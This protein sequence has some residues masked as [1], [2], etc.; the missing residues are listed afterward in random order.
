MGPVLA[1]ASAVVYGLAL[2]ACIGGIRT[3]KGVVFNEGFGSGHLATLRGTVHAVIIGASALGPLVLALGRA[4]SSSYQPTLLVLCL[5]PALVVV[6]VYLTRPV[7]PASRRQTA[8]R[9][10]APRWAARRGPAGRLR[11]GRA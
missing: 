11:G 1:I 2:G 3:L 4:W 6:A 5:L 8:P 7:R 10:A 9:L